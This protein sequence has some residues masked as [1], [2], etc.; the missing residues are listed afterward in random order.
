MGLHGSGR[1]FRPRHARANVNAINAAF[2]S[3]EGDHDEREHHDQD[4]ALFVF[5]EL[6]NPEQAFHSVWRALGSLYG[7]PS[8]VCISTVSVM[9]SE[10]KYLWLIRAAPD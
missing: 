10:A 9:L 2:V 4:D 5:R 3:D 7:P 8:A 6:E 1:Y